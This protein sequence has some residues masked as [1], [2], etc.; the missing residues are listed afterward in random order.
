MLATPL[1]ANRF[2]DPKSQHLENEIPDENDIVDSI[3]S[4]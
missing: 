4:P 2:S 1:P 3:S